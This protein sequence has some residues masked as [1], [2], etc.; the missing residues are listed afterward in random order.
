[1]TDTKIHVPIPAGDNNR[2]VEFLRKQRLEDL[3]IAR[4]AVCGHTKMN[5]FSPICVVCPND[6]NRHEFVLAHAHPVVEKAERE[7]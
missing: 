1:M 4:C 7:E 5:H 2:E 3:T 6:R